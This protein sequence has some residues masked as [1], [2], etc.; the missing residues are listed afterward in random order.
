MELKTYNIGRVEKAE[1]DLEGITVV[2]GEN[3]SGKS[4]ISKA[5]YTALETFSAPAEKALFQKRRSVNKAI[6]DWKTKTLHVHPSSYVSMMAIRNIFYQYAEDV[7]AFK[8]A[9][10]DYVEKDMPNEL[11]DVNELENKAEQLFYTLKTIE[12]RDGMYYVQYSVQVIAD[13]IFQNQISCLKES[14]Q[15]TIEY[16]NDT[17]TNMISFQNNKIIDMNANPY[18]ARE[19]KAI[20]ITTSDLM[21]SVGTYKRLYSAEKYGT[22]S[23]ANSELTKLLMEDM[24]INSLV[25]EE[26]HKLEEQKTLLEEIFEQVLEGE[27]YLDKNQLA[28]HDNWCDANIE[29]QN[30]ASGMK[31]FLILKRLVSNGTFLKDICLIIDEPETNLHPQWQL[32]LA[33][34]LVLLSE[35]LRVKVYLNSHSPYFVRAVEYYANQHQFLES[36]R[37]YTMNKNSNT[38]M[39]YSE[40]VT[41]NLGVIYDKLAE[42]FDQ[43]M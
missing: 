34:L 22:I 17:E 4:T 32:I 43:I 24:N 10:V 37:F 27:I 14:A 33:H 30:I 36:C 16:T 35:K 6:V 20:Y 25:A 11:L 21:D 39:F 42:P 9:L 13:S 18:H 41:K 38:G 8:K 2:A 28:Y 7:E 29:L 1:I 5:L 23:Y 26:Y 15:G 19:M 31:L 3:G 40:E 12:D